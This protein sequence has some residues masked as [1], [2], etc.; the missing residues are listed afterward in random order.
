MSYYVIRIFIIF[1]KKT[2]TFF[3]RCDT[4]KILNFSIF[5]GK[6][7]KT[8]NKERT[9]QW[10]SNQHKKGNISFSHK[11]QRPIGQWNSE[12]K[13]SLIHS[14]LSGF[15]INPI[16]IVD[17]SGV[18]YTLDGSQRTSTCIDYVNNV[19]ALNKNTPS[20]IITSNENGEVTIKEYQIA[21]KK[22]KKLD[23]DVQ[24]TLLACSL[25]F[26]TISEY[27]DSEI[28]EMFRRQ[29]N[30][31]PLNSKLLRITKESNDFSNI[32]YYLSNHP[33]MEKLI[34]RTQC[35]NGTD[36][37]LI[38]QTF[39][40]ISTN[41]EN[42]FTSFR[43][44]DIDTFVKEHADDNIDKYD[45]LKESMD[46]FNSSFDEITIPI[47][48]IPMMLYSGYRITKDKKSFSRLVDSIIEFLNNYDDNGEYKQFVMSATSSRENVR[49]RLDYWRNMIKT[50]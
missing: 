42:D 1:N 19:F 33:F 41:K 34:T 24:D 21:G 11:L 49:G 12:M 39:M 43:S 2:F 50:I 5:G 27:S 37:D 28:K 3:Y 14:L 15:P 35:K 32:V 47:T 30:G 9:I 23:K 16:Y 6:N 46:K 4:L 40:L 8:S 18:L 29:N 10:I 7:M 26:C 20:I 36:R 45:I 13:S 48:S 38:I 44:K 31:K 25:E 22:F 17:Q